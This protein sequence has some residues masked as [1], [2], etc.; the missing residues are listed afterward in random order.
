MD[1]ESLQLPYNSFLPPIVSVSWLHNLSWLTL[2]WMMC[3]ERWCTEFKIYCDTFMSV[4]CFSTAEHCRCLFLGKITNGVAVTPAGR[5]PCKFIFHIAASSQTWFKCVE[6][7][8]REAEYMHLTSMTF[9]L[10]GTGMWQNKTAV[11]LAVYS[12]VI[13][14]LN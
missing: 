12:Q 8:L 7:C 5:L 13:A 2:F 11:D 14:V 4:R 1:F 9:P 6:R 3:T 10:L